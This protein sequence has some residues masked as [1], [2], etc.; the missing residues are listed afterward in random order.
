MGWVESPPFFCAASETAR[1]VV[2]GYCETKMGT[3]P[4]QKFTNYVI[5]NQ[6]YKD[7]PKQDALDNRF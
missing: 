4:P 5:R 3:L 7:P 1:S 2:Q 6:A